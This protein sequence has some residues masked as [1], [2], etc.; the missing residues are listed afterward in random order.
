MTVA[1]I[2]ITIILGLAW[3][4]VLFV[5]PFYIASETPKSEQKFEFQVWAAIVGVGFVFVFAWPVVF[6]LAVPVL[7]LYG[8]FQAVRL[9]VK[10]PWKTS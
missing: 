2:I 5:P 7:V 8:L 6:I 10:K 1:Y 3:L 9:L 4:V